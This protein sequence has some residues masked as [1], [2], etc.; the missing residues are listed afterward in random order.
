MLI[1]WSLH[2][3]G[4]NVD[5]TNFSL[6]RT[7]PRRTTRAYS[8]SIYPSALLYS[9]HPSS[10]RES[11]HTVAKGCS[12]RRAQL[13]QLAFEARKANI[14]IAE[15]VPSTR[16]HIF[17]FL[18]DSTGIRSTPTL[19]FLDS[20]ILESGAPISS[21]VRLMQAASAPPHFDGQKDWSQA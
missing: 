5:L 16:P 13:S 3:T 21:L 11:T 12:G 9:V 10:G 1:Y 15:P 20:R 4:C 7:H 6:T 14:A 8:R 18:L 19:P 17:A 2:E